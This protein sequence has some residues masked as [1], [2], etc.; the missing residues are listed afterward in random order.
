MANSDKLRATVERHCRW[1]NSAREDM[2]CSILCASAMLS[3]HANEHKGWSKG[4]LFVC[5]FPFSSP[6]HSLFYSFPPSV[7]FHLFLPPSHPCVFFPSIFINSYPLLPLYLQQTVPFAP[8]DLSCLRSSCS[9]YSHSLIS[10]I[11]KFP[12]SMLL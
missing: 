2:L 1:A 11:N 9:L 5:L 3:S 8:V 7:F 12:S 6:V 10:K 4:C